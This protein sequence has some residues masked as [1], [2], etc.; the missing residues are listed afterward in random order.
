MTKSGKRRKATGAQPQGKPASRLSRRALLA[1]VGIGAVGVGAL[2]AAGLL[3]VHKAQAIT[4]EHD[5]S[6]L[7]QGVPVVVQVHDPQCPVCN[8]LQD[9]TRAALRDF[10]GGEVL[11]LI[12]NIRTSEGTAFATRHAVPHV[13]LLLFDGA[14]RLRDTLRG[15]HQ[16]DELRPIFA[17]LARRG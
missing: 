7:G 14:G 2:G 10:K 15:P 4:A 5:L 8:A 9:E 17:R 11:Y 16:A 13:T 6:R 12:A 1:R 3:G